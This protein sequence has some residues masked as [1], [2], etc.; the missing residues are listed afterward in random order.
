[1]M[2]FNVSLVKE[3]KS[4]SPPCPYVLRKQ[5]RNKTQTKRKTNRSS[6]TCMFP[7]NVETPGISPEVALDSGFCSIVHKERWVF[8][9]MMRLRTRTL[10]P[11]GTTWGRQIPGGQRLV[12]VV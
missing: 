5:P 12:S 9:G 8:R 10:S 2:D 6:S 4:F 11:S 7:V 1:M 3:E